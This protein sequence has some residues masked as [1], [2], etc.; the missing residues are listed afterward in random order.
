M[1][2]QL[3]VVI[4]SAL[5]IIIVA[6]GA[7]IY[8]KKI[9]S[10]R[11]KRKF[12]PEYDQTVERLRDREAAEA[13]LRQREKRVERFH[14]VPLSINDCSAYKETW[15]AVQSRFVDDPASAVEEANQLICEVMKKRG[16]PLTDFEQ[17]A[18]DLSVEHPAVVA[19]YRAA[20]R[21]AERNRRGG[22]ETE[23]LRQAFVH[24]RALFSDLLESGE[25]DPDRTRPHVDKKENKRQLKKIQG[26]G[27]RT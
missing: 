14:I 11:L 15:T 5:V 17:A 6:A 12:G 4:V 8:A 3:L 23:E 18:A 2:S 27:L 26:G 19:N 13:E 20:S 25:A 24:Y 1:D 10:Q 7:W 16:Y 9:K 21:I 22:A